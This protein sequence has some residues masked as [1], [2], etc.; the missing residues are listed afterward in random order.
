MIRAHGRKDYNMTFSMDQSILDTIK[1]LVGV[2]V[3]D[4]NFDLD[5]ITAI[6]ASLMILNRVGVGPSEGFSVTGKDE[7]WNDFLTGTTDLQAV[8]TY[9]KLKTTL[10]FDPPSSATVIQSIHDMLNEMEWTFCQT[11][12]QKQ[13]GGE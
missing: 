6:N 7:T 10:I 5:I 9:V 11:T 2:E 1:P 13:K 8:V 12:D 4:E 3:E